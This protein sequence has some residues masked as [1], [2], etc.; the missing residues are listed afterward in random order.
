MKSI[1]EVVINDLEERSKLA[2]QFD[3]Y[4]KTLGIDPWKERVTAAA[5]DDYKELLSDYIPIN[6]CERSVA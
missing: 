3:G 5:K 1:T 2:A 6:P 4:M